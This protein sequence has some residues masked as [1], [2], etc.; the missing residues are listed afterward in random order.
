MKT[1]YRVLLAACIGLGLVVMALQ[2]AQAKD[3]DNAPMTPSDVCIFEQVLTA[4]VD[5]TG[6][7]R[8]EIIVRCDQVAHADPIYVD[9]AANLIERSA[10]GFCNTTGPG[11][12]ADCLRVSRE[13]NT[14]VWAESHRENEE[15]R[16]QIR[17]G[18][19]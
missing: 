11:H 4:I 12:K 17:G 16:Q 10:Q 6:E 2:Y 5:E 8:E 3:A 18:R 19:R 13:R 14:N 9:A 1:I 15:R 7:T